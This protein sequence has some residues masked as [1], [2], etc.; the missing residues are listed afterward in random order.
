[1]TNVRLAILACAV[2][3]VLG[4]NVTLQAQVPASF[5]AMQMAHDV[6]IGE[7]WPVDSFPGIRLWDSGTAWGMINTAPG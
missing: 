4:A 3:A 1:M 7:P 2:G 6:M 5:F